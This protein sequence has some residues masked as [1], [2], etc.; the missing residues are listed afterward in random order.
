MS[1][2]QVADNAS[3]AEQKAG[4]SGDIARR[5]GVEVQSA[6]DEIRRI[7]EIVNSASTQIQALGHK[8]QEISGIVNVIKEVADQTNL[9]ALNAAIEAARAGEAG[10]GFAVV[11][12]E[13]RKL[14]E[15]TA[16]S[17]QEITNM[18]GSIQGESEIA[19]SIMIKGNELVAI[20]VKKAEQAGSSMV[21]INDSS[22]GVINAVS[23]ISSALREQRIASTDIAKHMEQ[24]A[25]MTEE[26]GAAVSEVSFAAMNLE[27]L[28][29]ELQQEVAKFKT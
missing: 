27:K 20:G 21:Q 6:V 28:A 25:Q 11:A 18:V 13:V 4:M 12:D 29:E 14:A 2:D 17:A 24:I 10:R 7:E 5:G 26:S 15:R 3:E 1:L 9:L 16:R 8:A 22:S 19:I 23:D